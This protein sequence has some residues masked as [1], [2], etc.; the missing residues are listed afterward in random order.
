LKCWIFDVFS[1][2]GQVLSNED[3]VNCIKHIKDAQSAAKHLIEEAVSKK[4]KDD[5]SCIVVKF[6]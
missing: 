3:A 6:Q 4:S 5:I 2:F 1:I